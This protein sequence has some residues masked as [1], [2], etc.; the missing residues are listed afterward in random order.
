MSTFVVSARKYRPNRFDEV[1]G[2]EHVSLTLKNALQNDHLAHAFL[3]CG[4]RGVGKTTCARILAKVL[5]CQNPTSSIAGF[6]I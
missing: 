5:N 6:K 1:V 2:Q 4:P 3:F